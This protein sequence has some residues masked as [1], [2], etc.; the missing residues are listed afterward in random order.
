MSKSNYEEIRRVRSEMSQK[1]GHDVR[2]LIA[3]LNENRSEYLD[4]I[5]SPG[6]DAE[7]CRPL[8]PPIAGAGNVP[9]SVPDAVK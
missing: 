5:I 3:M 4:R 1:A 8:A 2:R 9:Q 6:N 7:Q